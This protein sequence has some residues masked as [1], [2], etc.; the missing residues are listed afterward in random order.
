MVKYNGT[1]TY[2]EVEMV[3]IQINIL[4]LEDVV[5]LARFIIHNKLVVF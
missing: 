5:Y 1:E 4:M 2:I 3:V